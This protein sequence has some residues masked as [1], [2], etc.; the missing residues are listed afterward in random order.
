MNAAVVKKAIDSKALSMLL[1]QYC[2]LI[3]VPVDKKGMLI[4]EPVVRTDL[5]KIL[6]NN[7]PNI[8]QELSDFVEKVQ[9]IKDYLKDSNNPAYASVDRIYLDLITDLSEKWR[10]VLKDPKIFELYDSKTVHDIFLI[11]TIIDTIQESKR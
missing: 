1:H 10:V 11:V 4:V 9:P 6:P 3:V 7:V 5:F 2:N 8:V